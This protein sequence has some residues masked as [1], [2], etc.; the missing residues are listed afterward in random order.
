LASMGV[1]ISL[2]SVRTANGE[3]VGDIAVR[4]E[5]LQGGVMEG[6]V[7]AQL[8][9][10]LPAIAVLGPYTEQG[11]EIRNA[12]ELRLKESDRI[13]ALAENLR[14]MGAQVEERADGLRVAGRSAGRLHGAEIEPHGDH[15]MAMAFA[16]AALG[17]EGDT[18]IRDA[19]CAAVSYPDF[20]TTLDRL[21]ER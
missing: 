20:F 16:V 12:A 14:R 5:S 10:E 13:S 2:V 19:E 3:L 17:A 8:I 18:V 1:Q 7:I 4:Q 21:V 6:D 11:I 15:R 9:D